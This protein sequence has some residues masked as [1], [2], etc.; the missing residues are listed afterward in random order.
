M[1]V[2]IGVN[3]DNSIASVY[4][5]FVCPAALMAFLNKLVKNIY[6][7]TRNVNFI[8]IRYEIRKF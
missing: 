5:K 7:S 2:Q 8:K 6:S 4:S 1:A 3:K